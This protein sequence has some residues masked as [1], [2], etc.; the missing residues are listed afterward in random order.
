MPSIGGIGPAIARGPLGEP[1]VIPL[2]DGPPG[3]IPGPKGTGGAIGGDIPLPGDCGLPMPI[4]P[5]LIWRIMPLPPPGLTMPGGGLDPYV[6]I[7]DGP[8]P[9]P[10]P[11]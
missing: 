6:A 11:P 1:G 2:P 7:G 9:L 4:G 3:P 10:L 5:P 8:K